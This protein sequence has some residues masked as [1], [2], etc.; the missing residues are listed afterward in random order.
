M[1]VTKFQTV[2]VKSER[3]ESISFG[4]TVINAATALSGFSVSFG[5]AVDHEVRGMNMQSSISNISGF[6][7]GISAIASMEDN[8]NHVAN[9][10]CTVLV[11]AECNS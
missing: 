7:V 6:T 3:F 1:S 10:E 4:S 2:T 11:M 5:P 8:S 9:G